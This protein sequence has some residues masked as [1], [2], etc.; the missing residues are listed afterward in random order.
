[1]KEYKLEAKTNSLEVICKKGYI[2]LAGN[3]ILSDPK[4]FFQPT[5]DWIDVYMKTASGPTKV[6]LKFNYIDT[7]S[8]QS[9]LELLKK[10]HSIQSFADSVNINWYFEFDDPELLEIGEIMEARLDTKFNFIEHI[11]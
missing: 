11:L 4:T 6:D 7:A 3:S 10:L 1:M 8:V 2:S 9:I 5:Y